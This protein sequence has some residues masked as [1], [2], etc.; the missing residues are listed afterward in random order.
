MDCLHNAM[1]QNSLLLQAAMTNVHFC[2]EFEG[3]LRV[4]KMP[5][6]RNARMH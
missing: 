5:S 1:D 3:L 6:S 4:S 2:S